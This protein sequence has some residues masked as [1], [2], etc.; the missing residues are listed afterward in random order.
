MNIG[1]FFFK[2]VEKLQSL[3]Q[4]SKNIGHFTWRPQCVL[5]LPANMN[6]REESEMVSDCYYDWGCLKTIPKP[7][8][9]T[10]Y[11]FS[12]LVSFVEEGIVNGEAT[13]ISRFQSALTLFLS[14]FLFVTVLEYFSRHLIYCLF[15]DK[16]LAC[17]LAI[18]HQQTA[19]YICLST[20]FF[21]PPFQ[22]TDII[23][24]FL[25]YF[26]PQPKQLTRQKPEVRFNPSLLPWLSW[27]FQAVCLSYVQ[28]SS[29]QIWY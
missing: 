10:F 21:L 17:I 15:L 20:Y 16:N 7:H 14:V 26:L 11:Y 27:W 2:S 18:I 29:T 6:R 13:N 4:S 28:L 23:S 22:A 9:T 5:L 8:N 19:P 12:Y 25:L 24:V 3:L 1:Y